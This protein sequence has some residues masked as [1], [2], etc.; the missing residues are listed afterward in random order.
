MRKTGKNKI[1]ESCVIVV[2]VLIL[3]AAM[4]VIGI[5]RKWEHTIGLTVVVFGAMFYGYRQF[6]RILAFWM[7]WVG[8]LLMQIVAMTLLN[9]SLPET[10]SGFRGIPLIIFGLAEIIFIGSLVERIC[11]K[12]SLN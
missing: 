1:L 5:P 7:V 2:L 11:S 9:L 10:S 4:E 12:K 6:W 3:V 8:F